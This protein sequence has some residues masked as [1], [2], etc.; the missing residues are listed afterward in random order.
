M[1]LLLDLFRAVIYL[2]VVYYLCY[3][4]IIGFNYFAAIAYNSAMWLK[5]RVGEFAF[6]VTMF[7]AGFGILSILWWVFKIAVGFVMSWVARIC[8]YRTFAV[9]SVGLIS[10]VNCIIYLIGYWFG[11][12]PMSAIPIIV[13]SMLTIGCIQLCLVLIKA[14]LIGYETMDEVNIKMAQE[15][16]YKGVN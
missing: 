15:E 7:F 6:W 4:T 2:V 14:T 13:G 16:Y 3:F 8:T 9:W 10:A 11:G 1:K 5:V 12:E